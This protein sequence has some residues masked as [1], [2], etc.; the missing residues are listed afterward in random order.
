ML[1]NSHRDLLAELPNPQP[2]RSDRPEEV[3]DFSARGKEL[4][5][6]VAWLPSV[7]ESDS[8]ARRVAA[9]SQVLATVLYRV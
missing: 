9:I 6:K 7:E 2:A 3:R 8:V 5:A 1:E 4:A